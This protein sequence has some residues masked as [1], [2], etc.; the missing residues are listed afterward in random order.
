MVTVDAAEAVLGALLSMPLPDAQDVAGPLHEADWAD[1]RHRAVFGAIKSV[2]AEGVR[3]DPVVVS[4]E[5]RRSGA[6]MT[7]DKNEAVLLYELVAA[8]PVVA[9]VG[10]Y[11]RIL[12]EQ[13]ARRRAAESAVRLAQVAESGSLDALRDVVG[14]EWHEVQPA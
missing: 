7:A 2:L 1:P 9:S 5:L 11:V 13:A 4:G 10:Y 3:P 6:T 8:V 12:V 14:R